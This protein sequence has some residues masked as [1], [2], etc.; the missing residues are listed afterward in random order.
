MEMWDTLVG[1]QDKI[2]KMKP[3]LRTGIKKGERLV[4]SEW[5]TDEFRENIK[6][7]NKLNREKRRLEGEARLQKSAEWKAQRSKVHELVKVLKGG[8]EAKKTREARDSRD[9]GKTVWRVARELQGKGR[10][11]EVT[12]IY[13]DGVKRSLEDA[14]D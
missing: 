11:G 3:T 12:S 1:T 7:R 5:V 9:H 6:R 14:W 10:K 8:W 2:L 13:I 4:E